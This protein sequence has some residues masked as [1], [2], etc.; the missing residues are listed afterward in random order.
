MQQTKGQQTSFIVFIGKTR[1]R[2]PGIIIG[3]TLCAMIAFSACAKAAW[4]SETAQEEK[5]ATYVSPSRSF[6]V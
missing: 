6:S 3:A 4:A 5:S 2:L 1:D